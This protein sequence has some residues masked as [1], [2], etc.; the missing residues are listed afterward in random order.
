MGKKYQDILK[1][2][3]LDVRYSATD[4][5]ALVKKTSV[6][7]F[8][9]TINIAFNLNIDTRHAEQQIRGALVL[10]HGTGR[11]Q[12]ILVVAEGDAAKD[13]V[14]AKADKVISKDEVAEIV[15]ASSFNYDVIIATPAMMPTLG[16]FG[17][18]L[19]PKGL[20]P[21]PKVG[22]VT[23]DLTKAVNEIKKGKI[24]FRADKDG[25]LHTIIGKV[26]FSEKDLLENFNFLLESVKKS[27]PSVVK[28]NFITNVVI[29]ATM[30][31]GVKVNSN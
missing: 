2:N 19:G 1:N 9:A 18:I 28:G 7:N 22:T 25:N 16:R 11:S 5:I 21:N 15:K 3:D 27:R 23:N 14:A 31:P 26:S 20:M 10:P 29:S 8:D 30:G 13:A 17:K 24:T 12:K 4:A 6:V